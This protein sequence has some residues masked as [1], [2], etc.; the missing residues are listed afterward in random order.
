MVL[1]DRPGCNRGL[2]CGYA[3]K[4]NSEESL[5]ALYH[6]G[7]REGLL[8]SSKQGG[9]SR[10]GDVVALCRSGEKGKEG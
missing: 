10:R 5:R 8:A 1:V 7:H 9:E 2:L 4:C 6:L 3:G